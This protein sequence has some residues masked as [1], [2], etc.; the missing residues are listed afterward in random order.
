V[1]YVDLPAEQWH[2]ILTKQVGLP[3][4][5]ANHLHQ[6]AIDHQGGL[7]EH[8]TDTVECLTGTAP[9]NLK[10]FVREHLPG[11]VHHKDR[12]TRG[13]WSKK[14]AEPQVTVAAEVSP[15]PKR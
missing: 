2:A 8:K 14:S 12:C 11:R 1:E 13:V 10:E 6:A 5:L 3:K 4:F 7:F 9:Q 15:Q